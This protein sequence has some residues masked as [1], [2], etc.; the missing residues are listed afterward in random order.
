MTQCPMAHVAVQS[1]AASALRPR[2]CSASS[3]LPAEPAP[4]KTSE[5][6][7]RSVLSLTRGRTS[8]FSLSLSFGRRPRLDHRPSL[9]PVLAF[10]EREDLFDLEPTTVPSWWACATHEW[11]TICVPLVAL[12]VA[13]GCWFGVSGLT[14]TVWFGALYTALAMGT[15]LFM[16]LSF[17]RHTQH[18][19]RDARRGLI[20]AL[21]ADQDTL[22]GRLAEDARV[23]YLQLAMLTLDKQAATVPRDPLAFLREELDALPPGPEGYILINTTGIILWANPTLCEYFGYETGELI[24]QNIRALM[25]KAYANQHDHFVR[26]HVQ[27]GQCNILGRSR[28]VPVLDKSGSESIVMLRVDDRQDPLEADNRLF[29]GKMEFYPEVPLFQTARN[30][31]KAG[32]VPVKDA[33]QVLEGISPESVVAINSQGAILFA[34][35]AAYALF[36]WRDGE[37]LGENVRVL[38]GEPFASAHDGFL[39][40]YQRRA[41]LAQHQGLSQPTSSMVGSGRDLMAM[42]KTGQRVRVFLMVTR[43]DRPS[44]RPA[45][46][47]FVAKMVHIS[48]DGGGGDNQQNQDDAVSVQQ[49]GLPRAPTDD[50]ASQSSGS[51]CISITDTAAHMPPVGRLVPR[52]CTVVALALPGLGAADAELLQSDFNEVLGLVFALCSHHRGVP[53]WVVGSQLFV[54]FNVTGLPNACHR[55]SAATFMMQLAQSYAITPLAAHCALRMAAVSSEAY[56]TQWGTHH[57][58]S[59]NPLDFAGA[60]L[61]ASQECHVEKPVIDGALYEELQYNYSCR[62]INRVLQPNN[63]GAPV[64]VEVYEMVALHESSGDQWMY[65]MPQTD[66]PPTLWRQAWAHLPTDL[67]AEPLGPPP[68]LSRSCPSKA[69][70]LIQRHLE[71]QPEDP[72]AHWLLGV[73]AQR[74]E[75][76]ALAVCLRHSGPLTYWLQFDSVPQVSTALCGTD[77]IASDVSLLALSATLVADLADTVVPM[78]G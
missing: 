2:L 73:L 69:S 30:T 67:E 10:A 49:G 43:M 36:Q 29:L 39:Q 59:G 70:A 78:K 34:N 54:V 42:T 18:L 50:V 6:L 71:D 77:S 12:L 40:A 48:G 65:E 28:E 58:L 45:D 53:H 31:L 27:T 16:L 63:G 26:K 23:R 57:L 66:L 46:C 72:V 20:A 47:I 9:C 62:P 32:C 74:C 3:V 11:G 60:L 44:G 61:H 51:I 22:V 24:H 13:T 15:L 7:F 17:A 38:M 19:L 14:T 76:P 55:F 33:L 8:I 52:R 75:Q 41:F 1:P 35:K 64:V 5:P 21:A 25:P 56:C 37:L 4:R 68:H